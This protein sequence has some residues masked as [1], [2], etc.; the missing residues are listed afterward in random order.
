MVHAAIPNRGDGNDLALS[1]VFGQAQGGYHGGHQRVG[2]RTQN[3]TSR[4][5]RN[6]AILDAW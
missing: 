6:S 5:C 3:G 2:D 1:G 4:I